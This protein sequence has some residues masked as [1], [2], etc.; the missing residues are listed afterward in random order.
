LAG[1]AKRHF[2]YR[3]RCLLG[4][5]NQLPIMRLVQ[6][7]RKGITGTN[8][9]SYDAFDL[10]EEELVKYTD[11]GHWYV[12]TTGFR[13][14]AQFNIGMY[15]G[16]LRVGIGFNIG[17]KR[18]AS[19]NVGQNVA[20]SFNRFK[21][22]V[23]NNTRMF[24]S[25]AFKLSTYPDSFRVEYG[26]LRL[27]PP[28]VNFIRD[29]LPDPSTYMFVH[30]KYGSSDWFFVGAILLPNNYTWECI[31]NCSQFLSRNSGNE[32]GVSPEGVQTNGGF[33]S[34]GL[35]ERRNGIDLLDIVERVFTELFPC[36]GNSLVPP[37]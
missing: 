7:L 22:F 5:I 33:N 28:E 32:E 9:K 2:D 34:V 26:D 37:V 19:P 16:Y 12:F 24:E 21:D 35:E 13:E 25:T 3:V 1:I 18:H 8:P 6:P 23:L 4:A 17:R 27:L 36:L 20:N 11:D 14:M 29:V 10:R 30:P 15:G 31:Q